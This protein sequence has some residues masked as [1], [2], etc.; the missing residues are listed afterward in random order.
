[1]NT[2]F[3]HKLLIFNKYE[4]LNKNRINAPKWKIF[5]KNGHSR[6]GFGLA[7]ATFPATNCK[8]KDINSLPAKR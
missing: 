7:A 3:H 6:S 4:Y 5:A 1:M 8:R 2:T